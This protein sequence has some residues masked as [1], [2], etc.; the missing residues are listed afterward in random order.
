MRG[1]SAGKEKGC[2]RA[3]V[4]PNVIFPP[5]SYRHMHIDDLNIETGHHTVSDLL[6]RLEEEMEHYGA[7]WLYV[8]ASST[9]P[10]RF[11]QHSRTLLDCRAMVVAYRTGSFEKAVRLERGLIAETWD[12]NVNEKKGGEGLVAGKSDY[13]I[14]FII[15]PELAEE[16]IL[17]DEDEGRILPKLLAGS[18]VGL[19]LFGLF[20]GGRRR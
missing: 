11:S 17:V 7:E 3:V 9:Y 6:E 14:Y 18:L 8:G 5:P 4:I 19:G 12:Y 10:T 16:E 13:Y 2:D 1:G 15:E 20:R